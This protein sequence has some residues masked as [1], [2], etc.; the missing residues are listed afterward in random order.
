[1]SKVQCNLTDSKQTGHYCKLYL[2]ST[3]TLDIIIY[4]IYFSV[5]NSFDR[6]SNFVQIG[7]KLKKT[8]LL[9]QDINSFGTF[10]FIISH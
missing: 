5:D 4:C 9:S 10:T 7:L 3:N 8:F 2:A 6:V 1:M